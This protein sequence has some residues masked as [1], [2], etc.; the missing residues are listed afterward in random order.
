[1]LSPQEANYKTSLTIVK[2]DLSLLEKCTTSLKENSGFWK[3]QFCS[4]YPKNV[5]ASHQTP[6]GFLP[7]THDPN[8]TVRK[9]SG[10][11]Q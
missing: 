6:D 3:C 4:N 9:T 1:M 5:M 11:P 10:K 2:E 8:L 7:Q